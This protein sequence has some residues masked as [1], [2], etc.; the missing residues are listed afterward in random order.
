MN[1]KENQRICSNF[2][3]LALQIGKIVPFEFG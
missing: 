3:G 1:L 2:K